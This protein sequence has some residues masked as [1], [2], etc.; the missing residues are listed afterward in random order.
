L[1]NNKPGAF[2]SRSRDLTYVSALIN[3]LK[4][5]KIILIL[6][7]VGSLIPCFAQNKFKD[8]LFV[9]IDHLK[10]SKLKYQLN[11]G[12]IIG[13]DIFIKNKYDNTAGF[14]LAAG[15]SD[16]VLKNKEDAGRKVVSYSEFNKLLNK[17]FLNIYLYTNVYFVLSES[18]S[19]YLVIG[20][21][22]ILPGQLDIQ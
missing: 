19:E 16:L 12:N 21:R 18:L 20:V 4:M 3:I 1:P 22:P 14:L 9:R 15:N 11:K 5:K 17:D 8:S 13:I 7:L 10:P 2:D 6:V